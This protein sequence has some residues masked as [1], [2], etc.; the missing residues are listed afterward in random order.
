[1]SRYDEATLERLLFRRQYILSPRPLD[2][3]PSWRR[4]ALGA[5]LHLTVHPD[6]EISR[7]TRGG[8]SLTLL[9]FAVDPARPAADDAGVL[10]ALLDCVEGGGDLFDATDR[11]GGRWVL[12]VEDGAHAILF[13]DAAGQRQVAWTERAPGE[14]WS[15]S[16]PGLLAEVLA[17]PVDP[18]AEAFLRSFVPGRHTGIA[19]LPGDATLHAGVRALLPNHYLDLR[20]ARA[21]RCWPRADLPA[22]G[23]RA[24]LAESAAT[25]H[26]LM[27]AVAR[28][29]QLMPAV[30]AGWD[31]R[32]VLAASR[33][34]AERTFYFS[35]LSADKPEGSLD[36][37]VPARLLA[38]LGL[39]HELLDARDE[40]DE[41]MAAIFRRNVRPAYQPYDAVAQAVLDGTPEAGVIVS[42]DAGEIPRLTDLS[43]RWDKGE[44]TAHDLAALGRLP[45]HEFALGALDRWLADARAGRRNVP[46][47]ALFAW[48]Q[49]A[50]RQQV[51]LVSQ[52][53]I[54]RD[55][56][57]PC[58]C[59]SLLATLLGVPAR[60]RRAPTY[61]LFRS[62]IGRL[63]PDA[64]REPINEWR[65]VGVEAALRRALDRVGVLGRVP[66][67]VKGAAKRL[68]RH[69]R[70]AAPLHVGYAIL[71]SDEVRAYAAA[72]GADL[73]RRFGTNP[74]PREE[75]HITLKQAFEVP[76]LEPHERYLDELAA[77][78]EPFEIVLS[79]IGFFEPDIIFLDVEPDPRLET[80]RR[81]VLRDLGERFRVR[82]YPLEG[83]AYH[84]HATL[85][86]GLP[87]AATAEARRM[88]AAG[89]VRFRF[90]FDTLGL[91]YHTGEHWTVHKKAA[92]GRAAS[93]ASRR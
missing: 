8:R 52:L 32:L 57:A 90:A 21:T 66:R 41:G 9:G 35:T 87:P 17:L 67:P 42:G 63:W 76:S 47:S 1:M 89:G 91:L 56:F 34:S 58:N 50:G 25:L 37:A 74:A 78:I 59:R 85:A 88:L 82:P 86:Q 28:R 64:L 70:D 68:I 23:R 54:A 83:D 80:L 77:G 30:T 92:V 11:L 71:V 84:F 43:G 46:L 26:A 19:W 79:D 16:Q 61:Y 24:A 14:V 33:R 93:A 5:G 53:D 27:D 36:I 7:A 29:R 39:E 69:G 10:A 72:V 2:Q 44:V 55:T 81:K 31:S 20:S 38:R 48:E 60:E 6:L 12:I 4:V 62:L 65:Q 49:E 15:A 22:T 73:A 18:G 40:V 3:F 75:P 45:A 13:A 51:S